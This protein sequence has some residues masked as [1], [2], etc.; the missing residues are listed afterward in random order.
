MMS[1]FLCSKGHRLGQIRANG[2][3]APQLM[4][5]RHAIDMTA[6]EPAEVDVIGPLQGR[7]AVQ[8]DV[9]GCDCVRLWDAS[10]AAVADLFMR[11]SDEQVLDFSRRVLETRRAE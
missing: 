11:F 5:Y 9:A 10:V 8:C 2:D 1:D 7:M 3:G 6:T 4:L